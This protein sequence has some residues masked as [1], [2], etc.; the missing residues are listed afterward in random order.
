MEGLGLIV[1]WGIIILMLV[2]LW[3]IYEKAG[4][5]GWA[6]IIP[7]YNIVILLKI[8]DRPVWWIILFIIP[9]VNIVVLIIV[10]F[11]LGKV[12]GQSDG[13]SIGLIFLSFIFLPI[14]AFGDAVYQ[15]R[16]DL[17][18]NKELLDQF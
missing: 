4:E 2:S 8:V 1:Y 17:E 9:I 14:L 7:I 3:K 13:F 11:R 15:G 6:A 18:E 12:F 10:Y 16:K 5:P